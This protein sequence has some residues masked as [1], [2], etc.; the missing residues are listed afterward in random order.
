ML[1]AAHLYGSGIQ[2]LAILTFGRVLREFLSAGSSNY[3]LPS[4]RFQTYLGWGKRL[5]EENELEFNDEGDF[6][7]VRNR[8]LAALR[9]LAALKRPENVLDCILLDEAQDYTRDELRVMRSFARRIF[10]VGDE[11]QRI[12]RNEGA[13]AFL[14]G[15]IASVKELPFHYR[16]GV[17]ICRVA[18]G[19]R[20]LVG[21]DE[22]MEA[23]SNYDET[24]NPSTVTRRAGLSISEQVAAAIPDIDRQ[25]RAYPEALIGILCPRNKEVLD[26]WAHINASPL[27]GSAQLQQSSEGYEAF[28]PSRRVVVATVHSAKG[29]EFRALHLMGLDK[30]ARFPNRRR[31]LAYTAVT[32]AK[33]SLTVYH[34]DP[35]PGF[36]DHGITVAIGGAQA[37][38]KLADLFKKGGPTTR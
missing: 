16:N 10:A 2:N 30:I 11:R 15:T 14:R 33:T 23:T 34:E 19:I 20:N 32:R 24:R 22:G 3:E 12:Y 35:L 37:P 4:N 38:P 9:D 36:L 26:V 8:L 21:S 17:K 13:I 31:N 27:N 7:E 1:R 18:D 28:D 29:L 6:E 5:L 25:L